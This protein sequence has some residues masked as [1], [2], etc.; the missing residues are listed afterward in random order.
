MHLDEWI[1]KFK[2]TD[3]VLFN[4]V[5]EFVKTA[6]VKDVIALAQVLF[7]EKETNPRG[8]ELSFKRILNNLL[9]SQG[10]LTPTDLL[11]AI[12]LMLH[13]DMSIPEMVGRLAAS[14][15][16]DLLNGLAR[17]LGEDQLEFAAQLV[18]ALVIEGMDISI[19]SDLGGLSSRIIQSKHPLNILPLSLFPFEQ[20]IPYYTAQ[21]GPSGHQ[22]LMPFNYPAEE[23]YP[24]APGNTTGFAS[25]ETTT[26]EIQQQLQVVFQEWCDKSNGK[27]EARQ[28]RFQSPVDVSKLPQLL[29]SLDVACWQ[30]GSEGPVSV[31]QVSPGRIINV[32]F[33]SAANGGAY[34]KGL[35][36]AYG[37]L[38][39]WRSITGLVGA[40]EPTSIVTLHDAMQECLWFEITQNSWWFN[41]VAW[42]V[43]ILTLNKTRQLLTILAATD[44]D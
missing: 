35:G 14:Q 13:G 6:E 7:D 25:E 37:R 19:H 28:F 17:L 33:A 27:V 1:R 20:E 40:S 12:N 34:S 15:P 8:Y 21:Y 31:G 9:M 4:E 2:T 30:S 5:A 44:A 16:P 26:P 36:N 11:T 32:L 3:H 22:S 42:D 23:K 24:I 18:Q 43:G 38:A 41:D 29:A 10:R 39:V